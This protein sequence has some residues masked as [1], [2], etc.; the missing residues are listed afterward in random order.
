MLMTMLHAETEL[1][2]AEVGLVHQADNLDEP[3]VTALIVS[4]GSQRCSGGLDKEFGVHDDEAE[5][6]RLYEYWLRPDAER[7]DEPPAG[8][9]SLEAKPNE[10]RT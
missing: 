10:L 4:K 5:R 2:P 6:V 8:N 9:E 3:I 1:G 7:F